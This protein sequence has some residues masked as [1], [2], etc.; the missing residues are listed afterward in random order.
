MSAVGAGPTGS[1]REAEAAIR[2]LV[3]TWLRATRAGDLATALDPM[4]DDVVFLTPGGAPL[5]KAAVAAAS[6]EMRDLR[7]EGTSEILEL[8][9]E[10]GRA[11]MRS[12]LSLTAT[13]ASGTP[14][15]RAGH[16]LTILR[17]TPAGAWVIARDANLL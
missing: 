15:R 8:E 14:G 17:K 11:W 7:I 13:P 2:T 5:G 6:R 4:A 9:I 12:Q 16:T 1:R 3:D 10:G